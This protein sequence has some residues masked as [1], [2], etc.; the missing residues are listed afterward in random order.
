MLHWLYDPKRQIR[1]FAEE[2]VKPRP[3][4][5]TDVRIMEVMEMAL[6]NGMKQSDIDSLAGELEASKLEI[7]KN[8]QEKAEQL[9]Y[10]MEILLDD[11]NFDAAEKDFLKEFS[12]NIG[13]PVQ[14]AP[15]IIREVYSNLKIET[16]HSEISKLI[17]QMLD[18]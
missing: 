18:N 15:V 2:N 9:L 3:K 4:A 13:F 6:N 10:L 5:V 1:R 7:P 17:V 12:V 11:L 8:S 14:K 16:P